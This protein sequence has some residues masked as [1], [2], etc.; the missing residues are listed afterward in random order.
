FSSGARAGVCV[1]VAP[2][3]AVGA[4]RARLDRG[5][6]KVPAWGGERFED[7]SRAEADDVGHAVAVYVRKRARI[8]VVAAPPAGAGTKGRELQCRE[9]KWNRSGCV[10]KDGNV[11][12]REIGNGEVQSAVPVQVA[13]GD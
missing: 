3:A 12:A 2:P 8:G 13:N 9:C 5:R 1:A 10:Q 11:V 7:A 4:V 6:G